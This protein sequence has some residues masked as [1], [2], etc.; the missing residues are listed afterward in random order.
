MTAFNSIINPIVQRTLEACTNVYELWVTLYIIG[1]RVRSDKLLRQYTKAI[2]SHTLTYELK[3]PI[4]LYRGVLLDP[5]K[6]ISQ[7]DLWSFP[8]VSFTTD[9][10]V[11]EAFSSNN[12]I[13]G[14]VFPNHYV[15]HV[16]E[17]LYEPDKYF[18]WFDYRWDLPTHLREF[19]DFWNQS[20]I[21]LGAKNV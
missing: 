8:E 12:S 1:D 14:L 3:E 6:D 11:A 20:E 5:S 9:P 19:I 16:I 15:G 21:I 10:E 18:T 2:I 13:Y 7:H 4:K 17:L